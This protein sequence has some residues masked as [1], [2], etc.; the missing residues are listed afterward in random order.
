M[1]ATEQ[2]QAGATATRLGQLQAEHATLRAEYEK[3]RAENAE[4]RA[5]FEKLLAENQ[6]LRQRL[7]ELERRVG[8]DSSNS[9]KP[10][11]SDGPAKRPGAEAE[12]D[13]QPARPVRQ[14]PGRAARPQGRD[15][16]PDGDAESHRDPLAV[17][18]RRL[19]SV[20][21]GE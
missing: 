18:V 12:A 13:A 9:G 17:A 19:R 2:R 3:L 5:E 15:A 4:Q 10:P 8:L 1:P 14:A 6:Q 16:A 11:S 20:A 21:V 7:E